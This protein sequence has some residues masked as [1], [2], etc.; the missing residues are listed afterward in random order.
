MAN[1]STIGGTGAGTEVVR[2]SYALGAAATTRTVLTGVANHLYTIIS[3]LVTNHQGT[4][5]IFDLY[6]DP[7]GSSEKAY[8]CKQISMAPYG[9]FIFNDKVV[10]DGS[11]D[12]LIIASND[13]RE[14]KCYCSY[15]D[16]T[17]A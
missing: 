16:Q 1:P 7:D 4:E 3:V 17:F 12:D 13:S 6:I 14:M 5:C 2:R 9:T 10:M 8:L 15:I 11:G